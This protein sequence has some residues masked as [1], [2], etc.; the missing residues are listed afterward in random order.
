MDIF[1][2]ALTDFYKTGEAEILWLNNSYGEPEEMPVDFFFRDDEDMPVMELQALQMCE[3]T[4][5]D[6]GAGVGSH[7]LVLQAFRVDVTAIDISKSAVDIMKGRGVE[8]ALLQDVFTLN[9]KFD[10]IIMLMN[11]IGL[12][13]TLLGFKEFL[14]KLKDLINPGGQVLFDTSDISY[15]YDGLEKPIDK[16]FGEVS[17]QYEYKGEK[18]EWFNWLYVDVETVHKIAM[19]T[20]WLSEVIFDDDEDQYLV[21]LTLKFD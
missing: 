8:K 10:T 3:G 11:G 19:E 6:I 21:K 15:L 5:L 13:G 2:K 4:V 16:Y 18:G 7:A 20:G 9:A 1:G 14:I 17:Y 12:T